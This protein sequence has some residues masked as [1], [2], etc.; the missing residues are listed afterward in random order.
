MKIKWNIIKGKMYT[1]G[2]IDVPDTTNVNE[3]GFI[4]V[5]K[6]TQKEINSDN[7]LF[8][9]G[10]LAI[11]SGDDPKKFLPR[12]FTLSNDDSDFLDAG[13]RL[14]YGKGSNNDCSHYI[15]GLTARVF[16]SV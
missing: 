10:T 8:K 16:K 7:Y 15:T 12:I 11:E 3:D 9:G 5:L 2:I 4:D 14:F 6:S 13:R 1:G